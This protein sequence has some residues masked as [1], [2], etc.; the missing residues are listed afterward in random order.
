MF[1]HGCI[2]R[3]PAFGIGILFRGGSDLGGQYSVRVE[4]G[5]DLRYAN[6]TNSQQRGA[7][8]QHLGE[9]NL[10]N[11]EDIARPTTLPPLAGLRAAF[12]ERRIQICSRRLKRRQQSKADSG[13]QRNHQRKT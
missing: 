10:S 7:D 8:E 9:R 13:E 6:I 1:K 12:L 4:A 5:I 3:A 2:K 11:N